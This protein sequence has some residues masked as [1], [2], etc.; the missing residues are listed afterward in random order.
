MSGLKI[1]EHDVMLAGVGRLMSIHGPGSRGNKD[2]SQSV[3][4]PM[5]SNTSAWT[6]SNTGGKEL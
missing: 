3:H 2:V 4:V 6:F 5:R 1:D